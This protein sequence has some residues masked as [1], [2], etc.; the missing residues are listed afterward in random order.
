[1]EKLSFI[2]KIAKL[3]LITSMIA[4]SL[5]F[6]RVFQQQEKLFEIALGT[7]S[8]VLSIKGGFFI[9]L[10]SAILSAVGISYLLRDHS[11]SAINKM[12]FFQLAQHWITPV[13][14]TFVVSFALTN[15]ENNI[16]WWI[17]FGVG[18]LLIVL[19]LIAEY[20]VA[21]SDSAIFSMASILLISLLF[22]LYILLIV[23]IR[24]SNLRLTLI[25]PLLFFSSGFVSLKIFFL[26]NGK[27]WLPGYA[28]ITMLIVGGFSSVFHYLI[29][30]PIIYA[31]I[32]FGL[33]YVVIN[34]L[35]GIQEGRKKLKL[36]LESFIMI[37]LLI[38]L[39]IT[40]L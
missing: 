7:Y 8:L 15:M 6:T 29:L 9:N 23:S 25:L 28:I 39:S 32:Q 22:G 27:K 20:S 4:L 1:M 38:I 19:V 2:P 33:I 11:R 30:K 24:T 5:V 17:I 18:I 16:G 31:I 26:N 36:F 34:I 21:D 14:T 12:K 40:F 37:I 3:S 13:M 10:I 35:S